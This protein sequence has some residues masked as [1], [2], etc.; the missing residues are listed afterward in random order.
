MLC[1]ICGGKVVVKESRHDFETNEMYR[2]RVCKSCQYR[3]YTVESEARED[4]ELFST[5]ARL[6]REARLGVQKCMEMYNGEAQQEEA[7]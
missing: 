7:K 4:E 3:F 6:R 5:W 1:P 2:E